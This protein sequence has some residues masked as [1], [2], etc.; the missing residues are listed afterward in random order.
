MGKRGGLRRICSEVR[1]RKWLPRRFSLTP[2]QEAA[3]RKLVEIHRATFLETLLHRLRHR[4][5]SMRD[6]LRIISGP[7]RTPR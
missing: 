3:T 1:F 7:I 2:D 5:R 6:W 4:L